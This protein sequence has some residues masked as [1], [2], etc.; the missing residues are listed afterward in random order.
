M[1]NESQ[2]GAASSSKL[3]VDDLGAIPNLLDKMDL[4]KIIVRESTWMGVIAKLIESKIYQRINGNA[5]ARILL[6]AMAEQNK[7]DLATKRVQE[8][9][10]NLLG[11]GISQSNQ[12]AQRPQAVPTKEKPRST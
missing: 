5:I 3:K 11:A 7:A 8:N 1:E 6:L 2:S 10:K 9:A 4:E 12:I